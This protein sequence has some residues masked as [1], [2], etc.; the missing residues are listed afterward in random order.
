MR[1]DTL[2]ADIGLSGEIVESSAASDIIE[3]PRKRAT[4]PRYSTA[5]A[6]IIPLLTLSMLFSAS[7]P[8][9]ARLN[10]LL[11]Q[12][13]SVILGRQRPTRRRVTLAQARQF[14]LEALHIAEAAR[15]RFAEME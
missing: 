13:S 10:T 4:W 2:S 1:E 6:H 9:A 11:S 14:A 15:S 7:A 3:L 12:E 5:F 8:G